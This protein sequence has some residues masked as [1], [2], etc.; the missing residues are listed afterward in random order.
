MRLAR[1]A[2]LLGLS[3]VALS[4]VAVPKQKTTIT[5]WI[6]AYRPIDRVPQATS[7]IP[8]RELFLFQLEDQRQHNNPAIVKI[9]YGYSGN[10]E[11]TEQLLHEALTLRVKVKRSSGCDQSFSDFLSN[12]P[13]GKD[14]QSGMEVLNGIAFVERF[15][16]IELAPDLMLKCYIAQKGEIQVVG[17]K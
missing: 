8:N 12:I 11:V 2:I 17:D 16:N 14:E 5:G 9:D 3:A 7:A 1:L 15:K 13:K 10:S 6:I 4:T